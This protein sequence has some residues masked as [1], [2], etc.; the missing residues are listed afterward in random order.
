[1]FERLEAGLGSK[2]CGEGKAGRVTEASFLC[3]SPSWK[4]LCL[5]AVAHFR[6]M[7]DT[8][9]GLTEEDGKDSARGGGHKCLRGKWGVFQAHLL[10]AGALEHSAGPRS[11]PGDFSAPLL[12]SR[13]VL[14][15][16]PRKFR[17]SGVP[18]S[19]GHRAFISP[20]CAGWSPY[21]TP[22][23]RLWQP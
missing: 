15:D 13:V 19:Q 20:G 17:G 1:M 5:C 3:S 22:R 6:R 21:R 7:T 23:E 14:T 4:T 2:S 8:V 10:L 9:Q 12:V 11:P 16:Y 18:S